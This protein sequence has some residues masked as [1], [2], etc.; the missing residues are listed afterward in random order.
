MRSSVLPV[1]SRTFE[2]SSEGGERAR[3]RIAEV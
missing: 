1:A 3:H 2:D